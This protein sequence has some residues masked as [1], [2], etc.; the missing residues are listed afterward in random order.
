MSVSSTKGDSEGPRDFSKRAHREAVAQ[1]I[2]LVNA[3]AA[4]FWPFWETVVTYGSD[5][6]IGP[7]EFRFLADGAPHSTLTVSF[8]PRNLDEVE[9]T[10]LPGTGSPFAT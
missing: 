8:E 2:R 3:A 9:W 5:R 4:R 6:S 1:F 10:A 7:V